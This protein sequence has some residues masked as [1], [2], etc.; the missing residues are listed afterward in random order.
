MIKEPRARAELLKTLL[1]WGGR[2]GNAR[3]RELLGM[4]LSAV[5][6]RR[7]KHRDHTG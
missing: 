7:T 5:R 6:L 1:L 3:L 2:L 4:K